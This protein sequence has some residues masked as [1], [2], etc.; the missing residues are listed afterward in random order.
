MQ[1]FDSFPVAT[2]TIVV[3]LNKEIDLDSAFML[4]PTTKSPLLDR[5]AD[6]RKGKI[7]LLG[8]PSSIISLKYRDEFRGLYTPGIFRN[9]VLIKVETTT[10]CMSVHLSRRKIHMCGA[11]KESDAEEVSNIFI[12]H[13]N[14]IQKKIDMINAHKE[15]ARTAVDWLINRLK[16]RIVI[17]DGK[18]VGETNVLPP[19]Q[20]VSIPPKDLLPFVEVFL[21]YY[22]DYITISDYEWFLGWILTLDRVAP[23]D[24]QREET[25]IAMINVNYTLG[26]KV[27]VYNMAVAFHDNDGFV[28]PL[29][30]S[31]KMYFKIM[32]PLGDEY[33]GRKVT[34]RKRPAC[35]SFMI[36][37]KGSVTQSGPGFALMK[38]AYRRF[39]QIIA[40]RRAEFEAM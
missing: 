23:E 39:M 40:E 37:P 3:V 21:E 18:F 24:L 12:T 7:P 14:T 35:H 9:S 4:F 29:D 6:T 5:W 26:F 20:E 34:S 10:K 19:I 27:N 8:K 13:L 38:D 16:S 36:S 22:N 30:D 25:T 17:R 28:A 2:M 11:K 31:F 32:L 33:T 1:E 15:T